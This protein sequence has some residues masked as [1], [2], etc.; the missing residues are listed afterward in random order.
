MPKSQRSAKRRHHEMTPT[1]STTTPTNYVSNVQ[2]AEGEDS[3]D[4]I[5]EEMA[6]QQ[7]ISL[8]PPIQEASRNSLTSNTTATTTTI[9]QTLPIQATVLNG[10]E[11][12]DTATATTVARLFNATIPTHSY[13]KQE[14][15]KIRSWNKIMN[16]W[17]RTG[18]FS[19]TN[20]DD[21]SFV[22][23]FDV[24]MTR[25][26]K[27]QAVSAYL[28]DTCKGLKMPA[29]ER[30]YVPGICGWS[31]AR[32][33]VRSTFFRSLKHDLIVTINQADRFQS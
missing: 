12:N 1:L 22:P 28:L 26:F 13:T 30:W 19:N 2:M 18:T 33:F 14:L 5:L 8:S 23:S 32:S 29:F 27:V 15:N 3:I 31:S 17:Q 7:G 6:G 21:E 4:N 10:E 11:A 24:E 25:H 16:T 9:P 20:G